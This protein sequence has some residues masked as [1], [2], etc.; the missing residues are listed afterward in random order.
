MSIPEKL[1]ESVGFTRL[2]DLNMKIHFKTTRW[3]RLRIPSRTNLRQYTST[4]H[5]FSILA[6]N[7]VHHSR[8]L[9]HGRKK[10]TSNNSIKKYFR[11]TG[12][13]IVK[14]NPWSIPTK[15]PPMTNRPVPHAR[16]MLPDQKRTDRRN[17]QTWSLRDFS[18]CCCCCCLPWSACGHAAR[19]IARRTKPHRFRYCC[20]QPTITPRP[21]PATA[22]FPAA[23]CTRL[24]CCATLPY[25][26]NPR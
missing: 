22:N 24:L 6:A 1:Y 10:Q 14:T 4:I 16:D 5:G 13:T 2:L 3:K 23:E 8:L 17:T 15:T 7:I 19:L 12:V 11:S 9:H 21:F 18:R 26:T 20:R 25:Q